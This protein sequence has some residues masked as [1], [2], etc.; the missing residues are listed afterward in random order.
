GRQEPELGARKQA[1][2]VAGRGDPAH[3]PPMPRDDNNPGRRSEPMFNAPPL[4]LGVAV[5]LVAL[6]GLT[7]LL[8]PDGQEKLIYDYALVPQRFFAPAGSPD[9]YP[10]LAAKLV[11]LVSTGLLH[12]GWMHVLVNSGMLLAFG[13]Q[14][15]H[16][17]GSGVRGA[18]LWFA[19]LVVS[20][21]AGS[22]AFLA[23]DHLLPSGARA[24][25]GI[26]GGVSGLMGAAFLVGLDGRGGLVSPRF[27][28]M[29]FAFL[30]ANLLLGVG[31]SSIAGAGIAWQSHVGGYVAGA[32]MMAL[33]QMSR[34]Q[35]PPIE[36]EG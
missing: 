4:V 7:Y 33:L 1:T 23:F 8:S 31:G 19:L 13:A 3:L 5:G 30:L 28:T 20:T 18:L 22:L 14:V 35:P 17:L 10:N 6:H 2:V 16:L 32:A 25:V 21:G 26:S 9:A 34:R 36:D 11:T 12:G 27:L 24:A 29:T 15:L